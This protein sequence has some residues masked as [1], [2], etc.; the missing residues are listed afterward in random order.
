MSEQ[1]I[2]PDDPRLTAYVLG[3]LEEAER[4]EVERQLERSPEARVELEAIRA[5]A[6][7]LE[8]ELAVE[9]ATALTAEQ[10]TA[11]KREARGHR[12]PETKRRWP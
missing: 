2:H 11:I 12:A 5:T 3:E 10:R 4:R 9:P 7:L 8:A 6:E 1:T